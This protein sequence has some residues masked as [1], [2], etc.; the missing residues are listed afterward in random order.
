MVFLKGAHYGQI[1][2]A[3]RSHNG[4]I[5]GNLSGKTL[6]DNFNRR[7]D[8]GPQHLLGKES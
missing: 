1:T 4:G 6:D 7:R 8:D 3:T 2:E 5:N